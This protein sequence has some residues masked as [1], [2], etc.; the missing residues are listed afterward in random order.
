MKN[1]SDHFSV[2]GFD[3]L[4]VQLL[5]TW[6]IYSINLVKDVF[7][8]SLIK[9]PVDWDNS[10]TSVLKEFNMRRLYISFLWVHFINGCMRL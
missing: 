3:V 6:N 5:V 9:I 8:S 4:G 7:E 2:W 1:L 10:G